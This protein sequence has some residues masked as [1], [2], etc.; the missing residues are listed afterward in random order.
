MVAGVSIV[1]VVLNFSLCGLLLAKSKFNNTFV[2]DHSSWPWLLLRSPNRS[3]NQKT[4]PMPFPSTYPFPSM[5]CRLAR[6][7]GLRQASSSIK[8]K[9]SR[10]DG[11]SLTYNGEPRK[12]IAP[13]RFSNLLNRHGQVYFDRTRYISQFDQ[14]DQ[15]ILF[16]RPRR[17]GK[18]TTI[19]MLHHF[20]GWE[21]RDEH[22][23]SYQVSGCWHSL[24]GPTLTDRVDMYRVLMSRMTSNGARW[25]QANTSSWHWIFHELPMTTLKR[26]IG[27]YMIPSLIPSAPSIEI[28]R[29]ICPKIQ[30]SL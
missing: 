15:P 6:R 24:L 17:F 14:I 25:S 13:S 1:S 23:S 22:A 9:R 30:T 3:G 16:C 7:L 21:Y 5:A 8:A 20:H 28:T 4:R 11:T 12:F 18:T 19:N 27:L 26:W 10:V 29:G 2:G